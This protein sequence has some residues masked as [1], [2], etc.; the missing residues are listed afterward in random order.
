LK[1][2]P[3]FLLLICLFTFITGSSAQN[4]DPDISEIKRN[5][6]YAELYLIRHDFSRG[7]FSINYE[8]TIGIKRKMKNIRIGIY[9]DFESTVSFPITFTWISRPTKKG[10]FE[11]GVGAVIRIEKF[12]GNIYRDIPAIMIPL[13]YRRQNEEGLF[14]RAGFNVFVSWPTLPSPSFSLGYRF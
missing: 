13:M 11:Y 1:I 10:H 6:V 14:W 9:P 5:G 12:E 3:C 7:F 8:R 4:P 2:L